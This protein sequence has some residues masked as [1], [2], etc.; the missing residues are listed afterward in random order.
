M[1]TMTNMNLNESRRAFLL[2]RAAEGSPPTLLKSYR[3]I[4]SDFALRVGNLELFELTPIQIMLYLM[5]LKERQLS[6]PRYYNV[7]RAWLRWCGAQH[8]I[9]EAVIEILQAPKYALKASPIPEPHLEA[10]R[11]YARSDLQILWSFT[12]KGYPPRH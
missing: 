7:V 3:K 5:D 4:L 2:V 11:G 12:T 1:S 10:L 6:I 9:S 8:L